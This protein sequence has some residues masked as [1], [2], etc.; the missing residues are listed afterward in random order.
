MRGELR[1]IDIWIGAPGDR[2]R[3]YGAQMMR[4]A[5]ER[6]F[7][8][9]EVAAVLIDPLETNVR[10]RRFYERLGFRKIGLRRF[11]DDDCVVYEMR[12]ADWNGR[13]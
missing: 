12:R 1:A 4:L 9:A 10:A 3:G 5:L 13:R 2:G 8:P 6:C 7:A 11:G